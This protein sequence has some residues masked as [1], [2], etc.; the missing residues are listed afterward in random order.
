MADAPTLEDASKEDKAAEAPLTDRAEVATEA[1]VVE[2]PKDVKSQREET[3]ILAETSAPEEP[4]GKIDGEQ[5]DS[6]PIAA[7]AGEQRANTEQRL[8]SAVDVAGEKLH[9]TEADAKAEKA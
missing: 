8:S 1:L 6:D 9:V 3:A 7:A 2:A 4:E 5:Q